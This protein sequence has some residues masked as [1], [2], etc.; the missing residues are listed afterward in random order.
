M[1]FEVGAWPRPSTGGHAHPL[2]LVSTGSISPLLDI[3]AKVFPVGA[4]EPLGSLA[5]G[6]F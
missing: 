5:S 6:T 4:W 1:I 3:S 2:D